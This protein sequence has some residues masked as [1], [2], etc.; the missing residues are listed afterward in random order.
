MLRL[1]GGA[2][3]GIGGTL[4][5]GLCCEG[6]EERGFDR[7][8]GDG[9]VGVVGVGVLGRVVEAGIVNCRVGIV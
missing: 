9:R 4:G 8:G 1:G 5:C 3:P 6:G 2:G 7:V